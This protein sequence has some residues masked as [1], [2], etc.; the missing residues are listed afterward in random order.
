MR[1]PPPRYPIT[2]RRRTFLRTA[3]ATVPAA[4]AFRLAAQS[5]A[6][7]VTTLGP[8]LHVLA[9]A[10]GNIVILE[11]PEGLLLIDSGVPEAAAGV[12]AEAGKISKSPVARLINTHWHFDHVGGN[13]TFGKSG[14]R[15]LA[16]EN[17]KGRMS[18]RQTIA[19]FQRSFDPVAPEGLPAETFKDHGQLKHG[20]DA[21]HYRYLPPAHTDGDTTI[22][23]QN[24]NVYHGGDLLFFGLYPFIDYSSGGS[25][26]GMAANAERIQKAI[27]DRTKVVPGHGPVGGR[28]D[29][30]EFG[31]MLS[32]CLESISRL[33]REGKTLE[34]VQAAG[35]TRRFDA[36]WGGGML[37]PAEWVAMNYAGMRQAG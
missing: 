20:A 12:A 30:R 34:Q 29:V 19:F 16:H 27:D 21:L 22:H 1:P 13:A 8:K 23:F 3:L 14:A 25:L 2:M 6:L 4:A 26:A 28:K 32:A 5:G 10:G 15:I 11:G 31:D 18:T 17:T 37:K 35:P 24:A 36:K 33:I 7:T 9:G